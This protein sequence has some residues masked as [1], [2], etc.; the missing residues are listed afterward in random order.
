MLPG[1]TKEQCPV[2]LK[3]ANTKSQQISNCSFKLIS[4]SFFLSLFFLSLHSLLAFYKK[5]W[6]TT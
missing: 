2:S 4:L 1:F 6:H 5:I 3:F